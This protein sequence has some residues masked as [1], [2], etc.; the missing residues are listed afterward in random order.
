LATAELAAHGHADRIRAA[1][2]RAAAARQRRDGLR[3]LLGDAALLDPPDHAAR[4]AELA[5]LR[6]QL[7]AVR[8]ELERAAPHRRV[9]GEQLD[10][11]RRPPLDDD[12]RAAAAARAAELAGELDRLFLAR[13]ALEDVLAHRHAAAWGDAEQV[14]AAQAGLAPAL[15]RQHADARAAAQAAE[16]T[17]AA[18]DAAWEA[19]TAA[20]LDAD[21]RCGATAAHRERAAAELAALGGPVAAAADDHD[22]LVAAG[23]DH[24]NAIEAELRGLVTTAALAAERRDQAA[25]AAADARARLATETRDAGPAAAAWAELRDVAGTAGLLAPALASPPPAGRTSIQLTA[26]AWSKREVLLDRVTRARGGGELADAVRAL[27]LEGPSY[28]RGWQLTR[29]WLRHRVPAQVVEVDEP[30]AA[31]ERLR[32]QLDVLEGRLV[33]QEHDL[34]GASEDVARGIDV[35][36]RRAAGQIRRLNHQLEG[37]QFGSVRGIRIE[38]RRIDRMEQI[39]RA[40]RLG[41]AQ[42]LL[43]LS[44]IPIEEALDEIFRRYGGGRGGGERLLDY[45]EY[46]ELTVQIRRQVAADWETAS[47]TRLSTGEAIGVGAAIM[48]VVLTEWERD[49]NLIR[50]RRTTGSLRFLF[51][52]EAN[53]LSRDNL[54]VLFDLCRT[55]DLQL[56]IA[57]PEVARAEGNTT[58]RLVRHVTEDGREEVIVS[59]RRAAATAPVAE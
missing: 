9:L 41:E 6:D 36:L 29:E 30:L 5:G 44:A 14:F 52:D 50:A 58:Y 57:A 22:Q 17:E 56:L 53:R 46:L 40:L 49:A 12:H 55:L 23:I 54:G 43:F 35:Q 2:G 38:L 34:R 39:L 48:M 4:A 25:R 33:R 21:A 8:G 10:A 31:L 26:D 37:I 20:A 24:V 32:S 11:L 59:G 19:A 15:E 47:P 7:D 13:E 51:L 42:E 27:A 16:Q 18:A 28:L 45:R 1:A 3:R